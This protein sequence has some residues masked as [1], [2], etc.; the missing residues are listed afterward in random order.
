M[1]AS[2]IPERYYK[3]PL[4]KAEVI[5]KGKDLTIISW[6]ATLYYA[7]KAAAIAEKE[8]GC[9]IE[10]VDLR[11]LIPYDEE[12]LLKSVKKTG[13]C[14]VIH[15]G[16]YTGSFAAE[17][18]SF[19]QEKCFYHLDAPA[20]RLC[21]M[22]IKISFFIIV[23]SFVYSLFSINRTHQFHFTTKNASFQMTPRYSK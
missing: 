3:L 18:T 21:S 12:T 5:K 11:T 23:F 7:E 4:S 19:I 1:A 9:S 16:S 13:R 10:I 17:I 15:E 8:F 6:G 20:T 22:V 2:P 14:L